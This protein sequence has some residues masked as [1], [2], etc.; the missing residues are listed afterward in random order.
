MTAAI[1]IFT[2]GLLATVL[3]LIVVDGIAG[4]IAS[5]IILRPW[6]HSFQV[7]AVRCLYKFVY[8]S[9]TVAW[10]LIMLYLYSLDK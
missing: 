4:W 9:S 1:L 5:R 6:Q 7:L 3:Q 2:G 8:A 10:C